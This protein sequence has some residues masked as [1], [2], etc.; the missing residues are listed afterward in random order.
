[1]ISLCDGRGVAVHPGPLLPLALADSNPPS[2]MSSEPPPPDVVTVS[3]TLVECDVVPPVP[4]MVIVYVPAAVVAPA[5]MVAVEEPE[6][7]AAMDVGENVTLAPA[8]TPLAE[9]EMALLNPPETAVVIGE[10]PDVPCKSESDVGLAEIVKSGVAPPF[11]LLTIAFASTEAPP[12]A[13]SG[14]ERQRGRGEV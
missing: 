5:V 7:G 8:G 1:M 4:V 12:R 10:L 6:P 2:T 13:A 11:Q 14:G 9:R 3:E